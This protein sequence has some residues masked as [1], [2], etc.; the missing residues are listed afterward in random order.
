M[1]S[2]Q[3]IIGALF[4][5]LVLSFGM[6]GHAEDRLPSTNGHPGLTSFVYVDGTPATITNI[7]PTK[8]YAA[9]AHHQVDLTG[10]AAVTV[11]CVLITAIPSLSLAGEQFL[12]VAGLSST[13]GH[14][15]ATAA[16]FNGNTTNKFVV[17][18][19]L[20]QASGVPATGGTDTWRSA[21]PRLIV[22]DKPIRYLDMQLLERTGADSTNG[23]SLMISG[24]KGSY[25]PGHIPR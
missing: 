16:A 23:P 12:E 10:D 3:K 24:I 6:V 21:G 2:I 7:V 5:L 1:K 4:L 18:V 17:P 20:T 9:D 19:A 13:E 15:A 8:T 14:L 22:F 11:P 25:C